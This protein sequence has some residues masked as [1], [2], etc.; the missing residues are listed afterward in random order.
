MEVIDFPT[1]GGL[2]GIIILSYLFLYNMSF[3]N[4]LLT[5]TPINEQLN[6]T[7]KSMK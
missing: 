6:S 7:K 2:E 4:D 3:T 1:V 5:I